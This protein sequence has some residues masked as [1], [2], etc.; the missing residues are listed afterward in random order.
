MKNRNNRQCRNRY[1][2]SLDPSLKTKGFSP[3]ED[4]LLYEKFLIFGPKWC[5]ISK[6]MPGRS[7]LTYFN[8]LRTIKWRTGS[9]HTLDPS[10]LNSK[11][12]IIQKY[13][14]IRP[15]KPLKQ[16][17]KNTSYLRPKTAS[18]TLVHR[19]KSNPWRKISQNSWWSPPNVTLNIPG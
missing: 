1:I 7:V 6:E 18:K 11:I 16:Q 2:N 13:Q 14:M 17:G 12:P 8:I 5:Y 19:E 3:E 4:A 10:F 9:I 15:K